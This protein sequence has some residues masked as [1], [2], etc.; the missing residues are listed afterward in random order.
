MRSSKLPP[1]ASS[2]AAFRTLSVPTLTSRSMS[3]VLARYEHF[4]IKNVSTIS[5]LESTLRSITWV[6]PGRFRDAELAS[7]ALSAALNVISM[8][9]DTLLAQ[10]VQSDPKYKALIPPSPH[11]RYTRAWSDKDWRYKWAARTLQLV[12]FVELL[13]E[14]GLRRKTSTRNRWRGIVSLEVIKAVLRLVLLRITRRPV[15]S[16]PIPEREIDPSCLPP[17]SDTSSPTLAPSSPP[18]SLPSTPEHLKNNHVPLPLHPLLTPPPPTQSPLPVE[19]YLLPKALTT[20]AVKAPTALMQPLTSPKDWLAE[21]VYIAR[22]LVYAIMLSRDRKSNR[23]LMTALALEFVS[24]NLRRVPARSAP[25]ER[26]EYASRDKDI[27]WYLLRG[28]IWKTWSKPKLEAF[29]SGTARA[30]LLGVVGAFIR[31]WIPL[32]DEYYYYTAP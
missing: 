3:S 19:D 17:E 9:H 31:D 12:R 26:S 27:V 21:L 23:P 1:P 14:M 32:I 7:E 18:S 20:S 29:A 16:P 6:L 15:L 13:I 30:P 25:L 5:S 24:R 4:L 11:T 28:S 22:P 2:W 8:Y 10:F